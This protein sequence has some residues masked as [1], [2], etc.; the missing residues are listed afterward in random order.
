MWCLHL[1]AKLL[2]SVPQFQ[3][4]KHC[5]KRQ[6][7]LQLHS[8]PER[9]QVHQ[10]LAGD[11][12]LSEHVHNQWRD[13][14][15]IGCLA[16]SSGEDRRGFESFRCSVFKCNMFKLNAALLSVTEDGKTPLYRLPPFDLQKPFTCWWQAVP[17]SPVLYPQIL[18]H[19]RS[20]FIAHPWFWSLHAV[21][22]TPVPLPD[23]KMKVAIG[24]VTEFIEQTMILCYSGHLL[25]ETSGKMAL[26][27]FG[28]SHLLTF[29]S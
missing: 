27:W 20:S 26:I 10:N 14:A 15:D 4:L 6:Q 28:C 12:S 11:P 19:T 13:I 3:F 16:P 17:A 29:G 2:M 24:Q 5:W 7:T 21:Y 1:L 23:S 8:S 22:K 25:Q 18:S 9:P